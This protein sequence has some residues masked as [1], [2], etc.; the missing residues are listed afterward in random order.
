MMNPDITC[1]SR[2]IWGIRTIERLKLLSGKLQDGAMA[3]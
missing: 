3:V 1:S 2:D